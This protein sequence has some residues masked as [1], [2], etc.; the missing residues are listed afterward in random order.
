MAKGEKE[1]LERIEPSMHSALQQVKVSIVEVH[2][3]N[4]YISSNVDDPDNPRNW[5]KWKRYMV[6]GIA[7]WLTIIVSIKLRIHLL[8]CV[9]TPIRLL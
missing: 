5:S 3:G 6:A 4:I 1:H 9:L 7:S 8:D 2:D